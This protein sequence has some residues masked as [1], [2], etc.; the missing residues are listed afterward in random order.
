M[1]TMAAI[2]SKIEDNARGHGF[3]QGQGYGYG[4]TVYHHRPLIRDKAA[5]G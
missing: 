2:W 1:H 3:R 4:Y 5:Q